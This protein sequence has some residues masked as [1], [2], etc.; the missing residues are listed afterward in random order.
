MAEMIQGRLSNVDFTL[1]DI[2]AKAKKLGL[3]RTEFLLK[4]LE[5]MM[6]FD[7]VLIKRIERYSRKLDTPEWLVIQ[8]MLIDRFAEDAAEIEV[9]GE[10]TRVLYEFMKTNEGTLT[11]EELFGVLKEQKIRSLKSSEG[12]KRM[13]YIEKLIE[14]HKQVNKQEKGKGKGWADDARE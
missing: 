13:E 6:G 11:G 9:Y 3:T 10:R 2:D 1:A 12:Y 8:N 7:L 14:Q 5:M 4:S